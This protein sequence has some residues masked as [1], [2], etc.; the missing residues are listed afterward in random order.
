MA[1][2]R[3]PFWPLPERP[4]I[5][6]PNGARVA[7]WI[8][9]NIEH[10]HFDR[11]IVEAGPNA[12]VPDVPSYASRDYGNRIGVW[13]LMKCLDKYGIR[14]TVALN[15]DV[16][17]HEPQVVRAGMARNWEWMG[18][19]LT[20]SERLGGLSED[21][22]RAAIRTAVE[23]IGAFTGMAP[24][25]WLGPAMSEN[26]GT[27]DILAEHGIEYLCDWTADDQ[28]FPMRVKQGRLINVPYS[29]ELNDIRAFIRQMQT[30]EQFCQFICDQFDVLYEEGAESGRVMAIALH[31]FLIGQPF[32]IKWL[33]K[34]LRYVTDHQDVWLTT[35][36]EIADWY[37]QH[38]YDEAP[39]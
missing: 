13:R 5:R 16:C 17:E 35:G 8:I 12:L 26:V 14:G 38:Y 29:G 34:A 28:P 18:H 22:E 19:G 9:P 7:L 20:N 15:A 33:D 6:W 37:Y 24:R 21:Q 39:K 10:F 2:E 4:A 31:P 30:P 1:D 27:P 3:Y 11:P 36:C 23:R 32:R 25:G